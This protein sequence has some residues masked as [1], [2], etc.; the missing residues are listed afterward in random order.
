M[1]VAMVKIFVGRGGGELFLYFAKVS[2]VILYKVNYR[3][4]RLECTLYYITCLSSCL[5]IQQRLFTGGQ[6]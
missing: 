6:F 5:R 4:G 2:R 3:A 1:S